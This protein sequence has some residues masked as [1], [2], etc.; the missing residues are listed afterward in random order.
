MSL[1]ILLEDATDEQLDFEVEARQNKA[2][3][4]ERTGAAAEVQEFIDTYERDEGSGV[5]LLST[6]GFSAEAHQTDVN[7]VVVNFPPDPEG[8]PQYFT[9]T[10]REVVEVHNGIPMSDD[11]TKVAQLK[12]KW[13]SHLTRIAMAL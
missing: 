8:Q 1:N 11:L 13:E 4:E 6:A 10:A 12:Y 3:D 9:A 2:S 5:F 7:R